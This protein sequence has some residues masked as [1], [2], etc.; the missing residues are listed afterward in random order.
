MP[1]HTDPRRRCLPIAEWPERDR[2]AWM[3]AMSRSAGTFSG[4]GYAATLGP[5]SLEKISDGYG[6]WLGHLA[7]LGELDPLACPGARPTMARLDRYFATLQELGNRDHTIIGRFQELQGAL[8]ILVPRGDFRFITSPNGNSLRQS[9]PM[10]KCHLTTYHP[11]DLWHWGLVL[12]QSALRL[13]GP[14]RRQVQLRDGLL[15]SI[16]AFR[17]IRLRS[18]TSLTLGG[19]MTR[20]PY[21]GAWRLDLQPEDVKNRKYISTQLAVVL[22]P[23]LDRYVEVERQELLNGARSDAFWINWGGEK[24]EEKG[25]DKRI[26]WLSAKRFGPGNAFGTHRFRHCIASTAPIILPEY[27]GLAATLLQ[28]SHGVLNEHYDRG[29]DVMALKALHKTIAADRKAT[30]HL[31]RE[32]FGPDKSALD[33][34]GNDDE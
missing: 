16:L 1:R 4:R 34:E 8:R 33:D 14:K 28:I 20:D 30:E 32:A 13:R 6:R 24:L 23:W 21:S 27:P 26:R 17:G 7:F 22:A 2:L 9:L 19:S 18:I 11:I 12:M 15:I 10:S 31:A 5:K 29:S 3:E 25:V